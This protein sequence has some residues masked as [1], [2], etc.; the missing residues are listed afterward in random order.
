[1]FLKLHRAW[2]HLWTIRN[3]PVLERTRIFSQMSI[4]RDRQ[5]PGQVR[6]TSG[7][8]KKKKPTHSWHPEN[9]SC[10]S[11]SIKWQQ[12]YLARCGCRVQGRVENTILPITEVPFCMCWGLGSLPSLY[13]SKRRFHSQC[14]PWD[15]F[16]KHQ[17]DWKHAENIKCPTKNKRKELH[18]YTALRWL[19]ADS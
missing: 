18:Y 12:G 9:V 5:P 19:W 7:N 11:G 15:S 2:M 14:C 10:S 17:A 8:R 1:M 6:N 13:L 4:K 3:F 16:Y